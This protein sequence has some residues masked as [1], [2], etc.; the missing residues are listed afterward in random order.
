MTYKPSKPLILMMGFCYFNAS[1]FISHKGCK[2]FFTVLRSGWGTAAT[3]NRIL[4]ATGSVRSPG[5]LSFHFCPLRIE[6]L[7][8]AAFSNSALKQSKLVNFSQMW[9]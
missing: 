8:S 3:L 9:Y 5:Q 2:N 1:N 6:S 7:T 4:S